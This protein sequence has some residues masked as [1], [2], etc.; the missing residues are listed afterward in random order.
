M[1]ISYRAFTSPFGWRVH[2]IYGTER[3]HY[4]VDLAAPQGTPL[5]AARSGPVS[6]ATYSGD[7]G[8]YVQ[9][10]HGDGYRSIYMHMTHYVVGYGQ[11]VSRGQVIGYCGS[12]GMSTGSHL[13]FG[14]SLN[15]SY[16]NPA[17][18][19]PI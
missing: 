16:V 15:G 7:S 8:Y 12:T 18:Y 9:I 14:I 4:A 13:H 2:P 11:Y 10:N 5:Y 1:P 17:H 6:A 19:I 3:F